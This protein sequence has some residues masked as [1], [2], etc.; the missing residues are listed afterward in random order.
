M[1]ATDLSPETSALYRLRVTAEAQQFNLQDPGTAAL[2]A[3]VTATLS[4]QQAQLTNYLAQSH[5]KISKVQLAADMDKSV[6]S[7]LQS[8]SQNNQL[9]DA[10]K[11]YLKQALAKYQADLEASYK[12]VGPTGK[13]LL[14]EAFDSTATLLT[15]APLKS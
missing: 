13:S 3:T 5:T 1:S 11:A 8:A 2:A 15:N 10:Y 12:S 4:S 6:D 7:Q 14:K 9:D